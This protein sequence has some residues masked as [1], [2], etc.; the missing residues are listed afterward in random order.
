MNNEKGEQVFGNDVDAVLADKIV[1]HTKKNSGADKKT[2]KSS[3][4]SEKRTTP[5]AAHFS[6]QTPEHRVRARGLRTYG[7]AAL[8]LLALLAILTFF[9]SKFRKE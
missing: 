9:L 7:V 6:Y 3:I 8:V 4:K 5:R 2:T 1:G